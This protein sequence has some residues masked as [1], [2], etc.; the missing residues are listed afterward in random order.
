MLIQ[1]DELLKYGAI[2]AA[3]LN[4]GINLFRRPQQKKLGFA[5]LFNAGFAS[6]DRDTGSNLRSRYPS[7]QGTDGHIILLELKNFGQTSIMVSDYAR[8]ISISFGDQVNLLAAKILSE[9]PSDLSA[10]I[11]IVNNAVQIS[12]LL[13]NPNDHLVMEVIMH[14]SKYKIKTD[15]RIAG[16]V[17]IKSSIPRRGQNILMLLGL[18]CIF[19]ALIMRKIEPHA[20]SLELPLLLTGAGINILISRFYLPLKNLHLKQSIGARYRKLDGDG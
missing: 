13:L 18:A 15:T 14:G 4:S 2:L 7:E 10:T 8:P 5:V 1:Q 16:I 12:P 20:Q 6:L 11:Q 17:K 9:Y 3:L 19:I